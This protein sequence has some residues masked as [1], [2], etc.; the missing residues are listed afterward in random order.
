MQCSAW[1]AERD[2]W[3]RRERLEQWRKKIIPR[4]YGILPSIQVNFLPQTTHVY[5]RL[6][7]IFYPYFDRT[8]N[9]YE[10][11]ND[12][13]QV[14][15]HTKRVVDMM[16]RTFKVSFMTWNNLFNYWQIIK[17]MKQ[18]IRIWPSQML[19]QFFCKRFASHWNDQSQNDTHQF[20][21]ICKFQIYLFTYDFI[22]LFSK[23]KNQLESWHMAILRCR[24]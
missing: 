13:E 10:I 19:V 1:E 9:F 7:F 11:F 21:N 15:K 5:Y 14:D 22:K 4:W 2:T 18:C 16:M 17:P 24:L 6:K 12:N 8:Y 20:W 23:M 3:W